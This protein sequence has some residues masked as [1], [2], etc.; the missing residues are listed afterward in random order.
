MGWSYDLQRCKLDAGKMR[1]H[2]RHPGS[3]FPHKRLLCQDAFKMSQTP[4]KLNVFFFLFPMIKFPWT[5]ELHVQPEYFCTSVNWR[6]TAERR[7][8]EER[9]MQTETQ[10]WKGTQ[11]GKEESRGHCSRPLPRLACRCWAPPPQCLLWILIT[12]KQQSSCK[13]GCGLQH[14]LP[15]LLTH[16]HC[17]SVNL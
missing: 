3:T 17:F 10:V 14:L 2:V 8:A 5:F 16:Q 7:K 4:T 1:N 9:G 6:D 13:G 12:L 11:S 15:S